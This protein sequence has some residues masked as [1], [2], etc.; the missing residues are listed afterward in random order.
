MNYKIETMGDYFHEID[1]TL[2]GW[3]IQYLWYGSKDELEDL[4]DHILDQSLVE[5]INFCTTP[6]DDYYY[7]PLTPLA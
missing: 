1:V 7:H 2:N 3:F 5:Y 4:F 6:N